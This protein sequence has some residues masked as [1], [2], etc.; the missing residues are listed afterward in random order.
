MR[1]VKCASIMVSALVLG[2]STT[3]CAGD[4]I[5]DVT[6]PEDLGALL[7][8][9]LLDQYVSKDLVWTRD[10]TEIVFL[11][12]GLKAV[13][14]STKT[15]RTLSADKTTLSL[16]RGIG[17]EWIYF[18][19]IVPD[20]P[21]GSLDLR[22]SRVHPSGG[23]E[24]V[25]LV[26]TGLST[27]LVV[28]ANERW[29]AISGVLFDSETKRTTPLPFGIPF[30]FSPDGSRLLYDRSSQSPSMVLIST[31][32]GSI[33]SVPFVG[34][35]SAVR[36]AGNSPQF[37]RIANTVTQSG[38]ETSRISEQ[39]GL[40]GVETELASISG[41]SALFSA[42]W[43]DDGGILGFWFEPSFTRSE[44]IVLRRGGPRTVSARVDSDVG[45]PS[46]SPSGNA[47]AYRVFLPSYSR[48]YMKYI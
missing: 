6:E 12:D 32:D 22:I 35:P 23:T 3:G 24:T 31:A 45:A 25:T 41:T 21:P 9:N 11:D 29:V 43:S 36:W 5:T 39:D 8:D 20:A 1:F 18:V 14:L 40:S 16:A 4:G 48:I 28:S 46:F 38:G 30:G 33:Q 19:S 17:G 13:S 27:R 15:V 42:N 34:F 7:V 37:L 47:V 26:A 10:G 44:L 2:A